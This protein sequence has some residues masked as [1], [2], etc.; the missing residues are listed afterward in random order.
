[1]PIAQRKLLM[2]IMIKSKKSLRMTAGNF[3]VLSYVNFNA[4]R[5]NFFTKSQVIFLSRI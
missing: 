5:D 4:V 1:M 2:M 3:V